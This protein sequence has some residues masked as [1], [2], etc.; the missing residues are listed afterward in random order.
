MD[1]LYL[2]AEVQ[3]VFGSD[4]SVII[5]SFS[6][7]SERFADL[8]KVF[9]D[10]FGKRREIEVEVTKENENHLIFKFRNFNSAEDV[11][12][13]IGKKLYVSKDN[14]FKLPE[15]S[16]YIHDLVSSEV[17][18]DSLFFGKLVDVLKLPS[19][20]LFVIRKEDGSEIMIP[21]VE[22]YIQ[23]FDANKKILF[24]DKEC[25]IFEEDEN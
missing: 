23:S 17:F 5:K 8:E 13:F 10:F 2:I 9:I 24:L 15:D 16:Y 6:D 18:L 21:A 14:L 12:F 4:G 7:F 22:R 11:L 19:N 20:D 3:D 25:K 1:D